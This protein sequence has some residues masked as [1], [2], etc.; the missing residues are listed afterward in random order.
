[1]MAVL[2][3]CYR[4]D[5]APVGAIIGAVEI[6]DEE[7]TPVA[8]SIVRS[9]QPTSVEMRPGVYEARGRWPSGDHVFARFRLEDDPTAV[10]LERTNARPVVGT[11]AF[12][13]WTRG[14][15][16]DGWDWVPDARVEVVST[17]PSQT[18]VVP[19]PAGQSLA[20][21]V[22]GL[23]E[24]ASVTVVP[25]A[26]PLT[27]SPTHPRVRLRPGVESTLLGYL[28]R[29]D[30]PSAHIVGADALSVADEP[31]HGASPLSDIAIAYYLLRTGHP[32]AQSWISTLVWTLPNSVDIAVL[33]A[34]HELR[35][36]GSPTALVKDELR[37]AA[38][39][40]LPIVLDGLRLLVSA[41]RSA[42][43]VVQYAAVDLLQ[44]T[45]A[46][47]SSGPL[48]AFSAS[49]PAKPGTATSPMADETPRG[50]IPMLSDRL[51][52]PAG[53]AVRSDAAGRE[54]EA[55][56]AETSRPGPARPEAID[57]NGP[58]DVRLVSADS[59]ARWPDAH[60]RVLPRQSGVA[61][62]QRSQLPLDDE[63][64]RTAR[65]KLQEALHI[66]QARGIGH[67]EQYEQVVVGPLTLD[68]SVDATTTR[69]LYDLD[70]FVRSPQV[71]GLIAKV[72]VTL[73]IG[74]ALHC[75]GAFDGSER[76]SFRNIPAG[77]WEFTVREPPAHQRLAGVAMTLPSPTRQLAIA[78]ATGNVKEILRVVSHSGQHLLVLR[79]DQDEYSLEVSR[80]ASR[81]PTVLG[82]EYGL[83]DGTS[84]VVLV[85]TVV[86][87]AMVSTT[88]NL[89]RMDT[90]LPWHI[91]EALSDNELAECPT[92]DVLTCAG[93]A[94]SSAARRAWLGLAS[95][96]PSS[97]RRAIEAI[98]SP[99]DDQSS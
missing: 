59:Q 39:G 54:S 17:E 53:A 14:W 36:S 49:E 21:V 18:I 7:R 75:L 90:A 26:T 33:H 30:I 62:G 24:P 5:D 42:E 32:D 25:A 20:V 51:P 60:P 48:T 10:T 71:G 19:A 34:C 29:G 63:D 4:D 22:G 55:A 68:A 46:A 82:L 16:H 87:T 23:A 9:G 47:A 84:R 65:R 74:P 96:F 44:R 45:L 85:P 69:G 66:I 28:D 83:V 52:T 77:P 6:V 8:R 56:A 99:T 31:G 27:L 43:N 79:I 12:D 13:G 97:T 61:S 93:K 40:G 50:S 15:R 1:M 78:A 58:N 94:T 35:R 81:T 80:P 11:A 38:A 41:L 95:R 89:G 88:V 73:S 64:R 72:A 57:T 2:D 37:R 76:C 86:S 91:A 98:L 67:G 70:L 92:E 3:L